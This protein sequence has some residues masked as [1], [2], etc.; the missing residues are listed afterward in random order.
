[1][2]IL[3]KKIVFLIISI[4][5]CFFINGCTSN[6]N[7]S[8]EINWSVS[9]HSE[10]T[11]KDYEETLGFKAAFLSVDEITVDRIKEWIDLCDLNDGYYHYIN[12]DPD[13]WEMYIYYPSASATINIFKF[14]VTDSCVNVYVESGD[15][16]AEKPDYIL[17]LI[18][19]SSKG[20]WPSSSKLFIDDEEI[21]LKLVAA[22]S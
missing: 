22:I 15:I 1:M 21:E 8:E 3:I 2:V 9:R 13:S 6:T 10:I 7:E 19:A 5:I 4:V 12:S 17:L 18:Q 16:P 14:H 20:V 11:G